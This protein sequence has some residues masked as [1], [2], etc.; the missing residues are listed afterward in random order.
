[1]VTAKQL[2]A[3]KQALKQIYPLRSTPSWGFLESFS[4]SHLSA[5][6]LDFVQPESEPVSSRCQ[7]SELE[8]WDTF[9][10]SVASIALLLCCVVLGECLHLTAVL[11]NQQCPGRVQSSEAG[12]LVSGMKQAAGALLFEYTPGVLPDL[13]RIPG[14]EP[15]GDR[16]C[17][18][19]A[20]NAW[21]CSQK[22]C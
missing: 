14:F 13:P 8:L 4:H 12:T 19:H 16:I 17:T 20:G 7:R 10:L 18:A 9:G 11:G 15:R 5:Q 3:W 6:K 22:S 1:M 21:M 2:S